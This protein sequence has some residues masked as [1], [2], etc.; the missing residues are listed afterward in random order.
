[1]LQGATMSSTCRTT[2][3][4]QGVYYCATGLWPLV[5]L[6]TF[7]QVTGP[8]TDDWLVQTVGVLAA[9]I[10]VALLAGAVRPTPVRETIIL[11]LCGAFAFG[12]V[13][14]TF[15]LSGTISPIYLVDAVVQLG[16][17]TFL[18]I[19][20]LASGSPKRVAHGTLAR[21]HVPVVG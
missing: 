19:G 21:P 6:A 9:A 10:G 20:W 14:V 1:M 18:A 17:V 13:D 5:S 15:A 16:F 3:V 7:E 12:G 11:A 4:C 8:K 2:L